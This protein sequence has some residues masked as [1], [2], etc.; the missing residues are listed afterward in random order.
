MRNLNM[1]SQ[2]YCDID[3][4]LIYGWY[5]KLMEI[6]WALFH[7]NT[8]SD[9]LM[10]IQTRFKFYKVNQKLL[11]MLKQYKGI[12]TFLTARKECIATEQMLYD[13]MGNDVRFA[14]LALRTDNPDVDKINHIILEDEKGEER[15][16]IFDD[17]NNVR[18]TAR[19]C[20]IDAF[21]PTVMFEKEVE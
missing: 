4:T 11:Y 12:V 8:F 7:N 14:V 15:V 10:H 6:T 18:L 2:V 13:I 5:T 9:M 1:Y 19:L 20:D 3:N 17:N 16:C 21:D